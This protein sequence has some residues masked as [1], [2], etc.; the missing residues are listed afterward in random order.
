MSDIDTELIENRKDLANTRSA[1]ADLTKI[2]GNIIA[3]QNELISI[4]YKDFTTSTVL[5][6]PAKLAMLVEDAKSNESNTSV[7]RILEKVILGMH[8]SI[9]DYDFLENGGISLLVGFPAGRKI[10]EESIVALADVSR[11]LNKD[12]DYSIL[13]IFG[14]HI[15]SDLD[16][17]FESG[18]QGYIFF[19]EVDGE[20][21]GL[22]RMDNYG[23]NEFPKEADIYPVE[24]L[25]LDIEIV[26]DDVDYIRQKRKDED[27][28]YVF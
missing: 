4:K 3:E 27:T 25:H 15:D 26:M 24:R 12:Q 9:L 20:L 11:Y 16:D 2:M 21:C 14:T 7:V 10:T 22:V 28:D 13:S 8:E 17:S 5:K 1:I 6:D 19:K 23:V 18:K